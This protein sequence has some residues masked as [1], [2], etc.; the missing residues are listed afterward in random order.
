MSGLVVG[1]DVGGTFTDVCAL[2]ERTGELRVAK[3]PSTR[4]READGFLAGLAEVA[5]TPGGVSTIVHGTTVGT[6]ALLERRTATTG[7]ITTEGFADVLEMRRRDRP[8]TWGLSGD[9]E[10][11]IPRDRRLEVAE[12][13]LA[14]GRVL[15]EVDPGEVTE[16]A[17]ALL[18]GGAEACCVAFVNA[19]A[20]PA[21]EAR[22]VAA[23]R[24]VWPN[25]HVTAAS[26]ILPEIREFE[27]TSTV[28]LNAGLQPVVGGY[29]A[30]LETALAERG[31]GG[32]FFLVQSNGGALTARAA[33]ALPVRTALS[34]PA[35][36]VIACADLA[37][38]AGYENVITCD[39]GGTSF[40]VAVV[41]GGRS[42]TAAQTSIDFGLVI[43]TPMIEISTI[44]AGGGSVA[45]LDAGGLLRVGPESAGSVP[46]PA[47]YG[48]GGDRPTVTDAHLVLGRIN[49]DAP[50][51]GLD[52][53]DTAAARDA[54]GREIAGPLGLGVEE[55]AEAIIEVA[56]SSMAGA[57]RLVS[58]ERGLDP[59]RFVSMTFGGAG[60]L[61][62]CKLIRAT[63]LGGAVIPRHPGVVSAFG[64]L[65]ADFRH[66]IVRT[67]NLDVAAVDPE[68][69]A[70]RL[71]EA[72]QR[73]RSFLAGSGLTLVDPAVRHEFDMA[74]EG[75]THAIVVDAPAVHDLSPASIQD[76]FDRAYVAAYGR[77]LENVTTRLLS[78]RTVVIG[79]RPRIDPHVFAPPDARPA[80]PPDARPAASPDARPDARSGASP[81][82]WS[83]A[84]P[85]ARPGAPP[86]ASPDASPDAPPED[87]AA[88]AQR[89]HRPVFSDGAWTDT[90]VLARLDLPVGAVV[91]GPAIL[92][93]PDATTFVEPGFSARVD[94]FGNLILA[95]ITAE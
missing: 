7:L 38:A 90:P 49:G 32:S 35:A 44:G 86:A 27:R 83:G 78:F 6:N 43:R 18:A 74:Y 82:A 2:D 51:G 37:A 28:A 15:V 62:A 61:H 53:L 4:G 33:R 48:A 14:D 66:D 95:Q 1:I 64:C 71:G 39:M 81:D 88:P 41:A 92:E 24:A 60:A 12:R 29:L 58:I 47:C 23:V 56:T 21:N 31:F 40:D 11:V 36:G 79:R 72:E 8:R 57:I 34:G 5:P 73:L 19:Y 54:I 69:L 67:V 10:P 75:Q 25:E 93:Q 65:I 17:L 45:R 94:E 52:P 87:S 77:T 13:V 63:G 9:F 3:V 85:A 46:G 59:G 76:A 91:E 30:S 84:S 80:A 22:A 26:E 68:D 89:S 55:A 16:R 20:N 50:I 70:G 42:V